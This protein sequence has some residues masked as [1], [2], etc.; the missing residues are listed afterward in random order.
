MK[1]I[2][3]RTR[4]TVSIVN[5]E[6]KIFQER[7]DKVI[8]IKCEHK[9]KVK[10]CKHFVEGKCVFGEECWFLHDK[11]KKLEKIKCMFCELS[12]NSKQE[13]MNHRKNEHPKRVKQCANEENGNC[14][15]G[16]RLCWYNHTKIDDIDEHKSF[17][18]EQH[19]EAN[20]MMI[21]L[22]DMMENFGNRLL[23]IESERK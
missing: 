23:A 21:K 9:E 13:L 2:I 10:L 17:L 11:T 15:H 22:F 20:D 12:F 19:T 4:I 8:H 18:V 7:K 3:C 5:I 6:K 1:H 16:P 14:Q